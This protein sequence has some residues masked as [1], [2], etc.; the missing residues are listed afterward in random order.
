MQIGSALSD[1]ICILFGVPQG[2][3]L[4]PILFILYISELNIIVRQFGLKIHCFADDAQLYIAFEAIDIV[5]TIEVIESC[6]ETVK[7]W[8]TKMFLRLNE[9]KTQLVVISPQNLW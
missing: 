1:V 2:S 5:P 6:L 9:D 4:G 3:I 8:M 7:V